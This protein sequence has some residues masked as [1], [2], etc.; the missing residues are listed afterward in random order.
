MPQFETRISG[1]DGNCASCGA[2]LLVLDAAF[3]DLL[4]QVP[5]EAATG[6]AAGLELDNGR[7]LTLAG[8]GGVFTCPK[9]GGV[10]VFT[11]VNMN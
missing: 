7:L 10:G 5:G 9:C 8:N 2:R 1:G 11:P 3:G 6:S 4:R